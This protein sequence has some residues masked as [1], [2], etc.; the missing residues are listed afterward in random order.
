LRPSSYPVNQDSNAL[1]PSGEVDDLR[2]NHFPGEG[3]TEG[4]TR[5]VKG[6]AFQSERDVDAAVDA[7]LEEDGQ[8]VEFGKASDRR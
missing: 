4:Y 1:R 2:A 6:S 7:A 8:S 3:E 5:G